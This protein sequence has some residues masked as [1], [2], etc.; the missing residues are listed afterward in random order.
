M[1]FMP[2]GLDHPLIFMMWKPGGAAHRAGG[3]FP[4]RIFTGHSKE[5]PVY[6]IEGDWICGVC[7][8]SKHRYRSQ[9]V[10]SALDQHAPSYP[11]QGWKVDERW[12]GAYLAIEV[13]TRK[14]IDEYENFYRSL[15]SCQS[16]WYEMMTLEQ[17][18]GGLVEIWE[19]TGGWFQHYF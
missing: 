14:E 7:C 6:L 1:C 10:G 18:R 8:R 12:R 2:V 13:L 3:N 11:Q 9:C 4:P 19:K 5:K 15:G 16:W 17:C